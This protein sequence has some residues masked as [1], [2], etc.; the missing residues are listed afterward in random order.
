L[1]REVIRIFSEHKRR[2]GTRRI[3]A[4]LKDLDYNIGRD[5][6][7]SIMNRFELV[8]IQPKSFVPRTTQS[9]LGMRRSPNLL[10]DRE[11][12]QAPNKVVVGDITYLPLK[13]GSWVYLSI[14]QDL[15][16][17]VIVGWNVENSLQ[18]ELVIKSFEKLLATRNAKPGM[19]VHSDGGGQYGSKNFR[20][21]LA[22]NGFLQS[23]TR[24]DN[25]Y[26]NAMA[27]SWFSR[28]KAEKLDKGKFASLED[29][30]SS[31]FEYIDG[32]YNTR[33]RHS[34][35]DNKFPLKFEREW[36]ENN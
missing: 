1:E 3:V 24:R 12:P 22:S 6:V 13:D 21:I 11:P 5:K 25:H 27:E 19:I 17:K 9:R 18:E 36:E 16:S 28:F 14:W 30:R 26:D 2:Y 15:Y 31:C 32:Y 7:R 4:E 23:M 33:R 34:A 35:I 20:K 10:L 8:A 29:A